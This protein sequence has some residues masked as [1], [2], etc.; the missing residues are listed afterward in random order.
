MIQKKSKPITPDE[1]SD[2]REKELPNFVIDS[3]N[4][5][6][7]EKYNG[8]EAVVLQDRVIEI[9]KELCSDLMSREEI[10]SKRYLDVEDIYRKNGWIVEY[11]KPGFN[12]SYPATFKFKKKKK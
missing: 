7:L 1:I 12:E 6:I 4:K 2:V 8:S 9:M 5:A 3:F 10:F 11:D